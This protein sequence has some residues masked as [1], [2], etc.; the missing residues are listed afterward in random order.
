MTTHPLQF[1]RHHQPAGRPQG[2]SG[3]KGTQLARGMFMPSKSTTQTRAEKDHQALVNNTE[4]WVAQTFYGEMLKQMR[5]S[6]FRSKMFDGGEAGKT[7]NQMFDSELAGHLSRGAGKKLVDAIVDK[8]EHPQGKSKAAV[9]AY[10][11]QSLRQRQHK[12]HAA[13]LTPAMMAKVGVNP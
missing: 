6:P 9:D 2:P 12:V 3:G 8:I 1:G 11:A 10:N 7:Y 13:V 5:N 4:K